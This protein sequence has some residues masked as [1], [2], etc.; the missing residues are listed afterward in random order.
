MSLDYTYLMFK[1]EKLDI[2]KSYLKENQ[3]TNFDS[4]KWGKKSTNHI[5]MIIQK[6]KDRSKDVKNYTST[7]RVQLIQC[8]KVWVND[9]HKNNLEEFTSM[10]ILEV[11]GIIVAY[12]LSL[13][14]KLRLP[15]KK[16][17]TSQA[18]AII[19][20]INTYFG[21]EVIKN[22]YTNEVKSFFWSRSQRESTTSMLA[23][24][25]EEY[26]KGQEWEDERLKSLIKY[27]IAKLHKYLHMSQIKDC[28]K[29][30]LVLEYS[31][32]EAKYLN[33]VSKNSYLQSEYSDLESKHLNLQSEYSNL[34]VRNLHL[35]STKSRLEKKIF[36]LE[37]EKS[38]L[39]LKNSHLIARN[40]YLDSTNSQLVSRNKSLKDK[41]SNLNQQILYLVARTS[42]LESTMSNLIA[43]NNFLKMQLTTMSRFPSIDDPDELDRI[44]QS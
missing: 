17:H 37:E 26:E 31:N 30:D 9:N 34:K 22:E 6:L 27:H 12:I 11:T 32:L 16:I 23:K 13:K 14:L 20:H 29:Q 21:E 7:S 38:Y 18:S 33:L 35:E 8:I 40:S 25:H 15:E 19:Y 1:P 43:E 4:E 28:S 41:N 2:I 5:E 36:N 3:V 42:H 44:L 24:Y 39:A 10:N